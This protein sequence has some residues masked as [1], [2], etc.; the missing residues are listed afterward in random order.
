MDVRAMVRMGV[1]LVLG[2]YLVTQVRKPSRWVGR[3]F[4][5]LMNKS[6]SDLTDWGLSHVAIE[7]SLNILDVG[8]GGGRT[9]GKLAQMATEGHVHGID[10]ASGSVA[11]SRTHN[12]QL[13]EAGRVQIEQAS[14]SALPFPD[15]TFDLVTAVETQYYWPNLRDDMREIL[16]V[17]K[18]GGTLLI[19]AENYKGGRLDWIE[20]PLMKFILRSSRL[21]PEDQRH[22]FASAGYESVQVVEEPR[23]GWICITG[24]KPVPA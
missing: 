4:A 24:R 22:L 20:G 18:S 19:I 11:E 15:D 17:L 14:V 12:K 5:R 23:K 10:Y 16:R 3:P 21:T 2:G 8:C 7:K 9:V 13:I 1:G 6:H